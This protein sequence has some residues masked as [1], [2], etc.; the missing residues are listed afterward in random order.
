MEYASLPQTVLHGDYSWQLTSSV[1]EMKWAVIDF[2]APCGRY[3]LAWMG[4]LWL[5]EVKSTEERQALCGLPQRF[6]CKNQAPC[7]GLL[8][9]SFKVAQAYLIILKVD[10]R[11]FRRMAN[12][13]IEDVQAWCRPKDW[14]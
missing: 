5:R 13:V 8:C 9:L 3:S 11:K 2:E 12:E 7:L 1:G 10:D 14:I 6:C 4:K